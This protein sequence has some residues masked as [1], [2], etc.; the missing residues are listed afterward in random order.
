MKKKVCFDSKALAL[1]VAKY[2]LWMM[3]LTAWFYSWIYFGY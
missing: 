3:F 2:G 1:N